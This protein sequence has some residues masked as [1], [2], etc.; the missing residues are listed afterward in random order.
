MG[1]KVIKGGRRPGAGRK[2]KEVSASFKEWLEG[3]VPREKQAQIVNAQV[4]KALT[5]DTVAA[6][7]IMDRLHGK[8]TEN[9]HVVGT[10]EIVIT[11]GSSNPEN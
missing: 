1:I 8:P 6:S 2:R 4:E 9:H 10:Q 7:W 11:Y 5:G 3:L